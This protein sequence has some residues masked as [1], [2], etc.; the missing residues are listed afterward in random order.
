MTHTL[1]MARGYRFEKG[2]IV[3]ELS[4]GGWCCERLGGSSMGMPD[5]VATNNDKGVLL[6][7][8]AKSTIGDYAQ[9]P[10]D[11]LERCNKICRMF[12]YYLQKCIVLAFKFA[13]IPKKRKLRYYFFCIY[14][15]VDLK[16]IKNIS[17]NYNG[18]IRFNGMPKEDTLSYSIHHSIEELKRNAAF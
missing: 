6:A 11:Q 2:H 4:K 10:Y 1:K 3:K 16:N 12:D 5:E 8:E 14:T 17:C 18:T 13:G 9:I 7:I 15:P